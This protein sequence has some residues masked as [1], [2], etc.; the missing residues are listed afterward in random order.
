MFQASNTGIT[1]KTLVTSNQQKQLIMGQLPYRIYYDTVIELKL[2][3]TY[4]ID[5]KMYMG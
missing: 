1:L 5:F 4:L 3:S 2:L